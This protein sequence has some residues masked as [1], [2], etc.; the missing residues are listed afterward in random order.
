MHYH[1][2]AGLII[3]PLK[4]QTKALIPE[5]G[6]SPVDIKEVQNFYPPATLQVPELRVYESQ[7]IEIVPGEQINFIIKPTFSRHYTIQTYGH[8]DTVMTLFEERNG[9][10][11]FVDG[12]DDS[13]SSFNARIESRLIYGRTYHLRIRLY[14]AQS[15][16]EG[17]L[18]MW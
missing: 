3:E 1:F 5:D 14:F 16:G 7:R 15:Q 18:M 2:Q 9:V 6:L 8:L 17:A 10:P 13:G 12:D 4:Y 11:R